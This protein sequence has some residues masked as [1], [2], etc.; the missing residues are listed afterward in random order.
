MKK[1]LRNYI[2]WTYAMFF[3]FLL[4]IGAAMALLKS[5]TLAEILKVA[6]AW[7]STFVFFAMFRKIY[8]NEKLLGFIKRQFS[9][10][11]KISVVFCAVLLQGA[12]LLGGLLFTSAVQNV[13]IR[14]LLTTSWITLLLMF[15]NNLVRGS[16]GEE[17]GWRGFVL[18][19]LQKKFSPLK[20]AV[21]VGILWGFW[22]APLWLLSGYAG[23]Q[24]IQYIICFMVA[25][26]SV[27]IIITLFYNW[28]RNLLVPVIIHQLFNFFLGIQKG[29]L[30]YNI[31]VATLLYFAAAVV[32][33]LI[34]HKK[35]MLKTPKKQLEAS[36]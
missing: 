28:N 21:I 1:L 34:S 25:I 13:P 20:S 30:L 27:S 23:A 35:G 9:E 3:C 36:V 12:I 15:G 22:H 24:L 4:T 32:I 5:Q 16:L 8:P 26:V 11:L 33:V 19:E 31:T 17:L 2:F 29:N 14:S 18:N 10:K 6:S 7:T